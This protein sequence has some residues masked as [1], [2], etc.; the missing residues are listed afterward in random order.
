MN[1]LGPITERAALKAEVLANFVDA[2][3]VAFIVADDRGDIY[4]VNRQTELLFGYDQSELIGQPVEMLVPEALRDIHAKHREKY[5]E[6][7]HTRVMC[8]GINLSARKKNGKEFAAAITLGPMVTREGLYIVVVVMRR[9][10]N[11]RA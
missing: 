7:P 10:E 1:P 3:P 6:E 2:V 11:P 8:D 9:R 5:L 4:L